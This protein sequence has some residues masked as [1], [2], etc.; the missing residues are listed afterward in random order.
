MSWKAFTELGDPW[1][2]EIFASGNFLEGMRQQK[3]WQEGVFLEAEFDVKS[4]CAESSTY[5]P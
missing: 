2:S 4:R 1:T 3:V 5:I